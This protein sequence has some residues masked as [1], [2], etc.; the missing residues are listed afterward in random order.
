AA[1]DGD[2]LCGLLS[3]AWRARDLPRG[4]FGAVVRVHASGRAALLHRDGV[5]RRLRATRR[6]RITALTSGGAIPDTADYRVLLEPEATPIGSVHEDFAVEANAGDIFQL[7]NASWRILRVEPGV[8]RVADAQGTPPTLPFWIG[9]AP[10]RTRELSAAVGRL[11]E[12]GRDAGWLAREVALPEGAARQLA[13]YLEA[14]AR[15]LGAV[16]TRECVVL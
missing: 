10:A 8:V 2:A 15:A 3:G 12:R 4:D 6:A 13:E 14:G 9:E 7:G 16:P 11:R 1:G 5:G